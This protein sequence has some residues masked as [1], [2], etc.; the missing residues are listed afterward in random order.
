LVEF[1]FANEALNELLGRHGR[2]RCLLG[3]GHVSFPPLRSGSPN[4]PA[5]MR[6][7]R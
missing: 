7:P 3:L 6:S 1:R 5:R 4:L 2:K